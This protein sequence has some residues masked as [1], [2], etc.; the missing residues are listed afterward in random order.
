MG[1]RSNTPKPNFQ[2]F[3][4]N[5]DEQTLSIGDAF[6]GAC[7]LLEEKGLRNANEEPPVTVILNNFQQGD[8]GMRVPGCIVYIGATPEEVTNDLFLMQQK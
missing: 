8:N 4:M 5:F 3:E 2:K 1:F 7:E 6:D